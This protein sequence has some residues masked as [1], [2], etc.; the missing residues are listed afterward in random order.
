V[1]LLL[2]LEAPTGLFVPVKL[3]LRFLLL[4]TLPIVKPA[5]DE[6]D[7]V[8]GADVATPEREYEEIDEEEEVEIEG[9]IER[10]EES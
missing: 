3:E 1:K 6:L 9:D 8:E 4:L 5:N 10:K 7:D 2:L